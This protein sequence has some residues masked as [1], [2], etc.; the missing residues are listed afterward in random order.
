MSVRVRLLLNMPDEC[1]NQVLQ[2]DHTRRSP[3]LVQEDLTRALGDGDD[4]V[5]LG[6]DF[7][8]KHA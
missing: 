8:L 6:E 4:P 7:S 3:V 5:S 2:G 1:F